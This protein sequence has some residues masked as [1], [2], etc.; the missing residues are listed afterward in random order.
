MTPR[1]MEKVA[2]YR[3]AVIALDPDAMAKT[4][5]YRREIDLWTG[6]PTVAM[7]LRDDIKY[8]VT[9]DLTKLEEVCK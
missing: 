8:K 5:L 7:N 9:E 1:H 3:K 6:I 2:E 4:I